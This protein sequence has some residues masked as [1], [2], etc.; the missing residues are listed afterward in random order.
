MTLAEALDAIQNQ[1]D[2][3]VMAKKPWRMDSEAVIAQL[4]AEYRS[5][6]DLRDQGFVYF[7]DAGTVEEVLGVFKS[8]PSTAQQRRDLLF[9]Y[10]ENDAFPDWLYDESGD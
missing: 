9:Y 2:G 7:L 8:R 1:E 6:K 5:P 3:V 4:D 10:G